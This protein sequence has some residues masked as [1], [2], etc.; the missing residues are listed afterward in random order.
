[1]KEPQLRVA[2][3]SVFR[4]RREVARAA[5]LAV[6]PGEILAVIGPNGAGKSSLLQAIAWLIPARFAEYRFGGE[7]VGAKARLGDRD[8]LAIRRRLAVVFQEP[9]LLGGTVLDNTALG[10][11]L[12]GCK[13]AAAEAA[14]REWLGRLGVEHLQTRSACQLSHGEAQRVSLARALALAPEAL[15]LDEPFGSLDS[16]TRMNLLRDLKPLLKSSGAAVLLVTHDF[17]EVV[18]LADRVAAMEEGR[19]YP[20]VT[21]SELIAR[22]PS[23]KLAE[24]TE[25]ATFG[26]AAL[27]AHFSQPCGQPF[28]KAPNIP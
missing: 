19:L 2:D 18:L 5:E 16:V 22:P 8:V 13:T 23:A 28:D 27:L 15:F 20:A 12:R 14:S 17:T 24:M 6:T 4:G 10:L 26:A 7:A 1:M 25:A 11:K 9:L 3:L 21:V